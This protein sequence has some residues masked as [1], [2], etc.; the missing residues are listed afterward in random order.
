MATTITTTLNNNNTVTDYELDDVTKYKQPTTK[1]TSHPESSSSKQSL[2][3][4][5]ETT[6]KKDDDVIPAELHK[7]GKQQ[8]AKLLADGYTKEKWVFD[9]ITVI[10][11]MTILITWTI[12]LMSRFERNDVFGAGF[13]LIFG[14]AMAD[15]ISGFIHWTA[16]TWGSVELPYIGKAFIRPFRE[17]HVDPTAMTRHD[18]FETNGDNFLGITPAAAYCVYKFYNLSAEVLA[19]HYRMDLSLYSLSIFLVWTNQIHKWS[20]V[21]FG[22]PK[23]VEFLQ[24]CHLILPRKHHRIHHVM[25]HETYFCITTG[26]LNWPL[27][28]LRF[29]VFLEWAI[30]SLTGVPP[31][32]DDMRWAGKKVN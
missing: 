10:V 26:W 28:K 4:P 20:H 31:R 24:A 29:W 18:F 2:V 32:R 21:Y 9:R 14:V 25:P 8:R 19:E 5:G 7:Y 23:W 16:D 6:S 11:G 3:K 13:A 27:E 12:Q 30:E 22:L 1:L 17:H 15:F